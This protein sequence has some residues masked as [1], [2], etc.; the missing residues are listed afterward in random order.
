MD[1]WHVFSLFGG[2]ALFLFGMNL[3][4]EGLE[5]VAGNKMQTILHR[6][7]SNKLLGVLV[8]A[9]VTAVIQSSSA[10]TVMVVGFV[11]AQ[12]M[13]LAQAINVI[14]GANIGTTV[15]GIFIAADLTRYAPLIAMIGFLLSRRHHHKWIYWSKVILGMGFLFMGL[16]FM[17]N[18]MA[19]LR[20]SPTFIRFLQSISSP[21]TAILFG[22]IFT[23]I[24]QSSSASVGILQT[25]AN[26]GLVPFSISF[27]VV[28]GQNI[29]TC[30]TSVLASFNTSINA[31]RAALCHVLF[32]VLGTLLFLVVSYLFPLKELILSVAPST[33]AAQIA[34]LHTIFNITTT[35]L[36]LPFSV[37]FAKVST[38]L[39][40]GEDKKAEPKQLLYVKAD[41]FGDNLVLIANIHLEIE[42]TLRIC[43]DSVREA[44]DLVVQ[45]DEK[46]EEE[47]KSQLETVHYLTHKLNEVTVRLITRRLNKVQS[48]MLTNDLKILSDIERIK[49][50]IRKIASLAQTNQT[51]EIHFSEFAQEEIQIMAEKIDQIYE[52]VR[53]MDENKLTLEEVMHRT[54]EMSKCLDRFEENHLERVGAKDCDASSGLAY[55]ELLTSIS[56][57]SFHYGSIARASGNNQA[58]ED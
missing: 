42:R 53:D 1:I 9:G 48:Q 51:S 52:G 54:A 11:N 44:M 38:L 21:I 46:K 17:A 15:T 10:T 40:R 45:Y 35:L 37:Q 13:N 56:R 58:L 7:T 27:Y 6:L 19:P 31:K 47:L 41:T 49:D 18:S 24:I 2:L 39:I 22:T 32:N 30:I 8:G 55:S 16:E 12:L 23:A 25:L 28:L 20:E 3:M 34:F 43:R 4:S 57:I 14:M 26:Q 50:Y 5:L 29:G 36:L 33:P